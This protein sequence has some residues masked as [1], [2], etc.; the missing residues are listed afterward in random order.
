MSQCSKWC[1]FMI[2]NTDTNIPISFIILLKIDKP[3]SLQCTLLL[4]KDLIKDI[5]NHCLLFNS[6][7]YSESIQVRKIPCFAKLFGA[8]T[9]PASQIQLF[10][11][12]TDLLKLSFSFDFM[13]NIFFLVTILLEIYAEKI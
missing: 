3:S 2:S 5:T 12:F 11:S 6:F 10:L 8:E 4:S 9:D 13:I 1:Q 7:M